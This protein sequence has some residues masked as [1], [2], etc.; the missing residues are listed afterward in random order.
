MADI[1]KSQEGDRAVLAISGELTVRHAKNL[2]AQLLDALT[3][4]EAV[5]VNLGQVSAI[6]VT[7]PQLLCSAHRTAVVLKKNM[8]V[9]GVD[10]ERFGAM[11]RSAGI[12]RHIGC[13]ESSRKTCL[14]LQGKAGE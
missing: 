8:T 11:L 12:S 2:K 13:Q 7:F 4:S 6:D 10:G 1:R 3:G 5:E 14:W 9:T